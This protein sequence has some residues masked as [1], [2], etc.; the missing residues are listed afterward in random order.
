MLYANSCTLDNKNEPLHFLL[1]VLTV[2]NPRVRFAPR[3][4]ML[5]IRGVAVSLKQFLKL[6]EKHGIDHPEERIIRQQLSP[7]QDATTRSKSFFLRK[8]VNLRRIDRSTAASGSTVPLTCVCVSQGSIP[9]E[10]LDTLMYA[11]GKQDVGTI[12]TIAPILSTQTRYR[13]V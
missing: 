9:Q 8:N 5:M 4:G 11:K 13:S 12:I 2:V 10:T 3:R 7:R 1:Q 6:L